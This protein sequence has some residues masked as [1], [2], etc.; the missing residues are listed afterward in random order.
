M[1]LARRGMDVWAVDVSPVAIDLA[2][3]LTS[4][5]GVADRCRF[6]VVDLDDGLPEGPP[7]N[8]V[9]CYLFRDQ[10]LDRA[11]MERLA[12]GGLLAVAVLSEVGAGPGEFRARPGE[13]RDAYGEFGILDD[14]EGE[15]MAWIL[16]RRP[17]SVSLLADRSSPRAASYEG[18]AAI[19]LGA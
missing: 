7:V 16:A 3:E 19:P 4:L 11:V 13:L 6:D 9:L 10:R 12:F 17:G 2:R 18:L 5:S 8:L 14:G 1:W 15:G